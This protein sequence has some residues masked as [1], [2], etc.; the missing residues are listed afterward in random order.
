MHTGPMGLSEVGKL[1][2]MMT[3][4]ASTVNTRCKGH[5][6]KSKPT[7]GDD[8]EEDVGP[9]EPVDD[10]AIVGVRHPSSSCLDLFP[11]VTSYVSSQK[12]CARTEVPSRIR[13]VRV[14]D[15]ADK[16]HTFHEQYQELDNVEQV[17]HD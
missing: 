14:Q 17:V 6:P 9:L 8:N 2:L 10:V 11:F 13:K 3:V 1:S 4:G 15:V 16:E 7:A 5:G 12:L